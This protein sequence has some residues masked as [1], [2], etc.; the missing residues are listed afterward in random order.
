MKRFYKLLIIPCIVAVAGLYVI[1]ANCVLRIDRTDSVQDRAEEASD[2]NSAVTADTEA[3]G[4]AEAADA[5]EGESRVNIN[6]AT[7]EEIMTIDGIGEIYSERIIE[8]RERIGGFTSVEQL[9]EVEGITR[10]KLDRI[11][12]S[13]TVE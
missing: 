12:D 9:L 7:K 2:R 8:Q 10:K 6:T 5:F 4:S 1:G 13:I 11:R 3:D